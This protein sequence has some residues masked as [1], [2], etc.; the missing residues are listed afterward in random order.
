MVSRSQNNSDVYHKVNSITWKFIVKM[1]GAHPEVIIEDAKDKSKR[2]EVYRTDVQRTTTSRTP[3]DNTPGLGRT[4]RGE[5]LKPTGISNEMFFCYLNAVTQTLLGLEKFTET[6]ANFNKTGKIGAY[7][8]AFFNIIKDL[9]AGVESNARAL[10]LLALDIF[11]YNEQ[12]DAHEFLLHFLSKMQDEMNVKDEESVVR[13]SKATNSPNKKPSNT[14]VDEMFV[15][16][17]TSQVVCNACK[18]VSNTNEPIMDISLSLTGK[19]K[20]LDDCLTNY[21][22]KEDLSDSYKCEKCK[23]STKAYKKMVL[24]KLPKVLVIHLKRFRMFPKKKKISDFVS[25]PV[26]YLSLRK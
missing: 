8:K 6:M 17:V 3:S 18:N 2:A 16:Q 14:P 9:E 25:F 20:S 10:K 21:F 23:K 11:D 13:S 7:T 19:H 26:D 4:I 22:K 5:L 24:D 1:Y 15:G 12:H